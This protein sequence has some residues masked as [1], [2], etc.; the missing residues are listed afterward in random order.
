V[1]RSASI[2]AFYAFDEPSLN[3]VVANY[4]GEAPQLP[5][6]DRVVAEA[7][8]SSWG[9]PVASVEAPGE[10][11]LRR[12][13]LSD[14]DADRLVAEFWSDARALAPSQDVYGFNVYPVP[15]FPLTAPGDHVRHARSIAP[16][17]RIVSVLQGMAFGRI[18]G[19]PGRGR[20]PTLD[21]TRFQAVDS[22]AAGA[23]A[24]VWYGASSL[25]PAHPADA[26]LW[27]DLGAVAA[28]LAS[29]RHAVTGEPVEVP[30]S[31]DLWVRAHRTDEELVLFVSHRGAVAVGHR[32]PLDARWTAVEV[33]AGPTPTRDD[34]G[35]WIELGAFDAAILRFT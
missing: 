15:D 31:D 18:T 27:D 6:N 2:A 16:G 13:G 35:W 3:R 9:V 17:Q 25:D 5:A 23:D 29:V 26:A 24:I 4:L 1:P 19:D 12:A 11:M 22:I 7:A 21:E 30:G 10:L 28:E 20:A 32:L 34:A 33:V 14:D 8:R